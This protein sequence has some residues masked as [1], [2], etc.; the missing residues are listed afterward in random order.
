MGGK[1]GVGWGG[2]EGVGGDGR[3]RLHLVGCDV[4]AMTSFPSVR[5]TRFSFGTYGRGLG[6]YLIWTSTME[7]AWH[8][9]RLVRGHV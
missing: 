7:E 2:G 1:E 5:I 6:P 9:P 8:S 4:M 3:D